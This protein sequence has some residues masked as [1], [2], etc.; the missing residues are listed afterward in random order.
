LRVT[1]KAAFMAVTAA[2][3]GCWTVSV[4]AAAA[5]SGSA[6][7]LDAGSQRMMKSPDTAF[8]IR[9]ARGGLAE[10]QLGKLANQ[11]ATDPEIKAFGQ[12]MVADHTTAN[13]KLTAI[14]RK[15][16]MTLP[17]SMDPKDQSVYNKLQKLS[18]TRFDRTYMK[19]MTKDHQRDIKQFQKEANR[20]KD[21][22]IKSFAEE[23]LPVLQAHLQLAKSAKNL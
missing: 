15:Q 6:A 19:A 1:K 10:V 11:K 8:A 12:K 21:P 3:V 7:R 14:A 5:Q 13:E 4:Q 2:G 17:T 22:Q 9:A 16:E 23:T 18:G 20:G